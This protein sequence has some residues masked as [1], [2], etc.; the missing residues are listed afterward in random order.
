MAW[1]F[2]AIGMRSGTAFERMA[3]NGR[4]GVIERGLVG[5]RLRRDRHWPQTAA[6]SGTTVGLSATGGF[7]AIGKQR[8]LRLAYARGSGGFGSGLFETGGV[9]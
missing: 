3:P 4:Q 6:A 5:G 1:G 7:W 8:L 9:G 2:C